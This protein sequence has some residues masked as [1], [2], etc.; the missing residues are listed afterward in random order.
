MLPYVNLLPLGTADGQSTFESKA[1]P[2]KRRSLRKRRAPFELLVDLGKMR[3][4]ASSSIRLF[5]FSALAAGRLTHILTGRA[6][7]RPGFPKLDILE[8]DAPCTLVKSE[9]NLER[10]ELRIGSL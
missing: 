9:T 8:G 6:K 7:P 5:G 2:R 1:L 3:S 4:A 10:M